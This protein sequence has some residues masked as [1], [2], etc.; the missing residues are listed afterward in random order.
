MTTSHA[1]KSLSA[2]MSALT[3]LFFAGQAVGAECRIVKLAEL[4]VEIV[5]NRIVV[6][7][8]ING[9]SV[10]F[11]IDTGSQVSAI[12]RPAATKLGLNV[13][14]GAGIR[15]FGIG[16]ETAV[17]VT[18]VDEVKL[19][20]FSAKHLRLPVM[21]DRDD[22]FD[23]LLGENFFSR[24]DVEFDLAH[25]AVRLLQSADCEPGRLAYWARAYSMADLAARPVDSNQVLIDAQ[26]NGRQVRGMLDSGAELSMVSTIAA[27]RSGGVAD[28]DAAGTAKRLQGIGRGNL[29]S[30]VDTFATFSI[31]DET[32]KNARLRVAHMNANTQE[33]QLGSRLASH[34]NDLPTMLL[35]ADWLFSHRVVIAGNMRR[36]LFTYEGGPVFQTEHSDRASPAATQA[37]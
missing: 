28:G 24:V 30:W 25:G 20:N 4:P 37:P 32:V 8:E 23:V 31:G 2:V 17:G 27:E 1:E 21:G 6:K 3:M 5:H 15:V 10:R 7:G 11:L 36:L 16:G 35:G 34:V 22:G 29:E 19:D 12:W 13:V 33:I 18:T 14:G 9:Q 26:L